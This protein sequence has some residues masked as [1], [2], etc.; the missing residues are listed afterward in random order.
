MG[1]DFSW[2]ISAVSKV[3]CFFF[4]FLVLYKSILK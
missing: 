4:F 1:N 3:V 2:N